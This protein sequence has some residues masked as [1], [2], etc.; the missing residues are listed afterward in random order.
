M[1][2]PL[3]IRLCLLLKPTVSVNNRKKE[4]SYE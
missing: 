1:D 2:T 4:I 3:V